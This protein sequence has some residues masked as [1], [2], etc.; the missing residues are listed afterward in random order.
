MSGNQRR[1]IREKKTVEMMVEIY[2]RG[3]HK[4]QPHENSDRLCPQC[5]EIVDYAHARV[6]HC[7][8]I[9]NK[10]TCQK[11]IIHCYKKEK[12]ET[13]RKIMRYAGPRILFVHPILAV[14]HLFDGS[15]KAKA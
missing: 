3:N 12:R 2:C 14:M 6:D 4:D 1:I 8:L 13:I 15:K 5:R 11:C 10:P 7:P 9:E